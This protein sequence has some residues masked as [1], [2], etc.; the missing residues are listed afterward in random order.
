MT[1]LALDVDRQ[2]PAFAGMTRGEGRN[3]DPGVAYIDIGM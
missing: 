2:I 3:D 1:I